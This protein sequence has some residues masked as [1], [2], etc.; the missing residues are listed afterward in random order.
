M[1]P[2]DQANWRLKWH[3]QR[4]S[5]LSSGGGGA[6]G[7]AAPANR[8]SWRSM[9]AAFASV[10]AAQRN[11]H[12]VTTTKKYPPS[13]RSHTKTLSFYSDNTNDFSRR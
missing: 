12:V 1:H 8:A 3:S 9:P 13:F 7:L 11:P 5:A 4:S 6:G 10:T 2:C